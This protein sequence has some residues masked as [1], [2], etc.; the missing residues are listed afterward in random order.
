[1]SDQPVAMITGA[2][3]GIGAATAVCLAERGIRVGIGT[4]PGDPH[5]PETTLKDV[6]DGGGE[7]MIVEVDVRSTDSV[8]AFA[9]TLVSTWRRLDVAVANAGILREAAFDTLSDEQ[10]HDLLDVDLHG[11]MRTARAGLRHMGDG[12]SVTAIS[13]IAGGVYGWQAHAH[14]ATAKA[15]VLGLVRSLAVEYG[16]RGIRANAIIPGLI[17]TPQSTDAVNSLGPEGLERAGGYIPW[18]RVGDPRE[19][20][21]VIAFLSSPQASYVSGQAIVVD[22]A[23]TVA[24]RD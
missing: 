9:E 21:E 13:S 14:Y 1:M 3:S 4:F 24:M 8:D 12:G 17:R 10:W 22:G 5:D 2:A 19:V 23:L 16:P 6:R 15:G 18:G 11:V 20:A 7:G